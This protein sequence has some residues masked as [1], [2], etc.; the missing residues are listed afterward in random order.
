[1]KGPDPDHEFEQFKTRIDL[2]DFAASRGYVPDR[3]ESS[4][5]CAIMR[6]PSGDKIVIIRHGESGHWVF[7]APHDSRDKGTIVNFLRN[8]GGGSLGEVRKTLRA[9]LGGSRP[10][11][12]QLP[13]FARELLPVSKDRAGV[14]AAW[15]RARACTALPYLTSR[16]LGPDVLALPR[17]AGC[18]RVDQRENA[19]F[20]H[21][22]KASLCG[23]E[24]KNKGFTGFA[25][26]GVKGLWCSKAKPTDHWLV[27]TESAIDAYSFQV[28]HG[29]DSARFMSTG[30]ALNF[31]QP[32]LLRGA[33]EKMPEGSVIILGF[34]LDE[35]GEKLAQEVAAF[36][37][38]GRQ[39][40][41]MLPD[42]GTG[43]DWNEALKCRFGLT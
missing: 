4:R 25:P 14:I 8:R 16:G 7:Y 21:F 43:K 3:R 38:A 11:G 20:P 10:V 40:R 26:G 33:M 13:A 35:G 22:D 36:A 15:E 1:M 18:V 31:Q 5:N 32:A 27:L 2:R 34:D 12:V 19:L 30:G 41:R 6:H 24:S 28:L 23:F 9:W 17:F 29:G 37:P 39:L 42:A